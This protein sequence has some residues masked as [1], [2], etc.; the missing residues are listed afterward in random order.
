MSGDGSYW[1]GLKGSLQGVRQESERIH[2]ITREH[3][4]I[5]HAGPILV[6]TALAREP[7]GAGALVAASVQVYAGA[8]VSTGGRGASPDVWGGERTRELVTPSPREGGQ[9]LH[10]ERLEGGRE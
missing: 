10:G 6:L 3:S 8:V 4:P 2:Q 1:A 9:R 7:K 5:D